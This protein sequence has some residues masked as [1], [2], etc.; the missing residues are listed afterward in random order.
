[1]KELFLTVIGR[2]G[3][4]LEAMLRKIDE[5]HIQGQ[6]TDEDKTALYKAARDAAKPL[7]EVA[8]EVLK[9]STEMARL[10]DRVAAA[11]ARLT[12]LESNN[13]NQGGT[14][15]EPEPQEDEYPEYVAPTGAH[16][17]YNKGDKVTFKGKKYECL[18]DACVWSPY[19]Y[20]GC[21]KEVQA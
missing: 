15:A 17:A 9:L 18:Q 7:L 16:N 11:E 3:F 14:P 21:W 19:A 8:E 10:K 2:G 6:L 1:M 20:P 5:Y 4:D 12:A 13:G